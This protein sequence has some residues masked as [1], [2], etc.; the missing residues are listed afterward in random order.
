MQKKSTYVIILILIVAGAAL[1][2]WPKAKE[3]VVS[4]P[5][6]SLVACTMDAKLCPDGSAVGR[7]GPNC[8]FGQCPDSSVASGDVTLSVGQ[9]GN[10]GGLT[11]TLRSIVGDSRCP[12]DVN[13]IQAGS[14]NM[15]VTFTDEVNTQTKNISLNEAPYIF[16]KYQVSIASVLPDKESKKQILA[17][18][19]R[20]TFHVV[21]K[22]VSALGEHCGGNLT[23]AAL[24]ATGLHCAAEPGSHLPFGDVGGI[25]V[26]DIVL[27]E[28]V[29]NGTVTLSPIC[30]VERIPQDPSCAPKPYQTTIKV[31]SVSDNTILKTI[32]SQSDGGFTFTLPY[33]KYTIQVSGG[34]VYPRCS[35]VSVEIKSATM[36]S[37]SISC[38]TGIR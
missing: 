36:S 18:Q 25:C 30:P 11:I 21:L 9:E 35:P 10:V 23:T 5:T 19:Y 31:S 17:S 1:F 6:P 4:S 32:Q 34:N 2:F 16:D 14:V 37:I 26:K 20:V 29:V 7:I 13:C 22:K 3:G 38:D 15:N 24:C 12:I 8:E 27:K 33:G 28:G